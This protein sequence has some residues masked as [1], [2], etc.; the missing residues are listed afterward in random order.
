MSSSTQDSEYNHHEKAK[1]KSAA[2]RKLVRWDPGLDQLVLLCV[3]HVCTKNAIAIPWDEVAELVEPYLTGEAI[4]QHLVK[5][6]KYR[7][8]DGQKVPP[9]LSAN[10]RRKPFGTSG[11]NDDP[12]PVTKKNKKGSSG[13]T[14][15]DKAPVEPVKPGGSLLFNKAGSKSKKS[16]KTQDTTT[17]TPAASRGRKQFPAPLKSTPIARDVEDYVDDNGFPAPKPKSKTAGRGTKRG[18]RNVGSF[19]DDE[20]A[21]YTPTKQQKTAGGRSFRTRPTI[22]YSKQLDQTEDDGDDTYEDDEAAKNYGLAQQHDSPASNNSFYEEREQDVNAYGVVDVPT[23]AQSSYEFGGPT[24]FNGQP[25]NGSGG[26]AG[27]RGYHGYADTPFTHFPTSHDFPHANDVPPFAFNNNNQNPLMSGVQNSNR[28]M[29]G[30]HYNINGTMGVGGNRATTN[31]MPTNYNNNNDMR[32]INSENLVNGVPRLFTKQTQGGFNSNT[33]KEEDTDTYFTSSP[34]DMVDGNTCITPATTQ[35][36]F[37]PMPPAQQFVDPSKTSRI[38]NSY[39][40]GYFDSQMGGGNDFYDDNTQFG[41]YSHES[42]F[43]ADHMFTNFGAGDEHSM[44]QPM[45]GNY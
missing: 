6:Y 45:S 29:G 44:F 2:G 21:L 36:S 41:D 1:R 32:G 33:V 28:F 26:V 31:E 38:N 42:A 37:T 43:D 10:Q 11:N 22:D 12:V 39:D 40:S 18:N 13:D 27:F 16:S 3:D 4:K 34:T 23:P 19:D 24:P 14:T 15:K 20:S 9:K 30:N 35:D 17:A 8:T 25:V 7:E 5:I